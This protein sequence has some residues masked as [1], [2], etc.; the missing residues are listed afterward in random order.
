M[1]PW[2]LSSRA[3]TLPALTERPATS[4]LLPALQDDTIYAIIWQ[5]DGV[6]E[7]CVDN[8][9]KRY[10]NAHNAW[11]MACLETLD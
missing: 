10:K 4:A 3:P 5:A 9:G 8:K 11:R 6:A 7:T 1:R 2:Q